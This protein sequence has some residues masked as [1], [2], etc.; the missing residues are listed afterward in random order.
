MTFIEMVLL[1]RVVKLI[2]EALTSDASPAFFLESG[3]GVLAPN[4][5]SLISQHLLQRKSIYR[6]D[7]QILILLGIS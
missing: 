2:V 3:L 1:F 6:R 4:Q 7:N 5:R